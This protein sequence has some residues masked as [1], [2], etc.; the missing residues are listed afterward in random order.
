MR[1]FI[2]LASV[3]ENICNDFNSSIYVYFISSNSFSFYLVNKN[4]DLRLISNIGIVIA[5]SPMSQRR[6]LKF[7][8]RPTTSA[9]IDL[10]SIIYFICFLENPIRSVQVGDGDVF[11]FRY[12]KSHKNQSF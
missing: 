8:R 12:E 5:I 9:L 11:K 1:K 3:G 7:V 4:N 10:K 6:L 2:A